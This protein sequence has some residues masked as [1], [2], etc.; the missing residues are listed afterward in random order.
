TPDQIRLRDRDRLMLSLRQPV[1]ADEQDRELANRLMAELSPEAIATA[2][3]KALQTDLPAPED[4]LDQSARA[5][6]AERDEGPRPGF[7]NSSWFRINVGRQHKADPRWLLPLICR[8][9]HVNRTEIGAIRI[10]A[11][12]TYFEVTDRA[13]PTF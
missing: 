10:A 2:L 13:A 6:R 8:H 11:G 1:E 4:I 9:G 5:D 7:E 3:V 12:E